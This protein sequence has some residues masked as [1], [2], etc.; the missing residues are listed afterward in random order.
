MKEGSATLSVGELRC[1][2]ILAV[3]N[4]SWAEALATIQQDSLDAGAG[5]TKGSGRGKGQGRVKEGP[6]SA[7]NLSMSSFSTL[8]TVSPY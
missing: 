8:L 7:G 5:R 6:G 2:R 3:P 1:G 4:Q